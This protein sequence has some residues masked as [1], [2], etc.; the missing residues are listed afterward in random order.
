LRGSGA[1]LLPDEQSLPYSSR[2]PAQTGCEEIVCQTF[3]F[4]GFLF[5]Y[6]AF[7]FPIL[8]F[9]IFVVGAT[10]ITLEIIYQDSVQG[11]YLI[12]IF[13]S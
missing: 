5:P 11:N 2:N 7:F 9:T 12:I 3:F 1:D 8:Y 4:L 13:A 6:P 10:K